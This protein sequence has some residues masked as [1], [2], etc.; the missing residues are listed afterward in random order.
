MDYDTVPIMEGASRYKKVVIQTE[1]E[2][3]STLMA[4]AGSSLNAYN[5]PLKHKGVYLGEKKCQKLGRSISTIVIHTLIIRV[6]IF[7]KIVY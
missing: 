6:Y 4:L 2:A 3:T 5:F 1:V 7:T